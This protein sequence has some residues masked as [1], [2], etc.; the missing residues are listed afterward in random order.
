MSFA[1]RTFLF[2]LA[3]LYMHQQ[4]FLTSVAPVGLKFSIFLPIPNNSA[5]LASLSI[6]LICCRKNNI[7]M[8]KI[9]IDEITIQTKKI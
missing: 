5:A 2:V 4:P 7:A 3:S 1:L 8:D 6:G 9:K